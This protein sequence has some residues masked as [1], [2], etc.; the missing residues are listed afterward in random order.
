MTGALRGHHRQPAFTLPHTN[1]FSN[2][3]RAILPSS[4]FGRSPDFGSSP[5]SST[6]REQFQPKMILYSDRAS[7]SLRGVTVSE[8]CVGPA[9]SPR[10]RPIVEVFEHESWPIYLTYLGLNTLPRSRYRSTDLGGCVFNSKR[11]STVSV[12]SYNALG[13]IIVA[14]GSFYSI[15]LTNTCRRERRVRIAGRR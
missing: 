11:E 7:D 10:K 12:G 4:R 8:L 5:A 15:R 3:S 6:P 14:F 1:V 9:L 2:P 13:E